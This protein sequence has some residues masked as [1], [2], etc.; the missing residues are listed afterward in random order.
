VFCREG[1]ETNSGIARLHHML[2]K[3]ILGLSDS[4]NNADRGRGFSPDYMRGNL[5]HAL[6][7][8]MRARDLQPGNI[9]IINDLD[10]VTSIYGMHST[11]GIPKQP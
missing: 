5:E 11:G 1:I 2:A 4:L 8:L 7:S 9:D 10:Y 3:S 6:Q